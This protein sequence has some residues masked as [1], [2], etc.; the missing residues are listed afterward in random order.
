MC[1]SYGLNALRFHSWSPPE[2]AFA[3]ADE[4]GFYLQPE[5][6]SWSGFAP[7]SPTEQFIYE[8]ATRILAAFGN[9]PS[10]VMLAHGNEPWGEK[11]AKVLFS[12]VEHFKK[13]D[14]RRLY[15][16]KTG[17]S[18]LPGDPS[19]YMTLMHGADHTLMRGPG[20]WF[21][22]D[23][24]KGVA[25]IAAPIMTHEIGQ[26][27][28]LP[29][30]DSLIAS[31]TGYMRPGNLEVFRDI[32]R[33]TGMLPYN[34]AYFE[35]SG[36]FQVLC[37][38]E[39]IEANRRTP[40]IGGFQL[41]DLRDYLGQGTS[42]VGVV[43]PLWNPKSYVTPEAYRRFCGTTAPL[44]RM[45]RQVYR[46]GEK[47]K[48]EVEIAHDG[49][50]PLTGVKPYWK[51][52]RATGGVIARGTFAVTHI[53]TGTNTVLGTVEADLATWL[54]PA[55]YKLVVGL[56]GTDVENDWNFWL[57]PDEVTAP[58]RADIL[59]TH[60]FDAVEAR[61]SAGGKVLYLPRV[62]DLEWASPMTRDLPVFWNELLACRWDRFEGLWCD[63]KHPALASFPTDSHYD[64]Q[65][66]ELVERGR[67]R[68]M[69]LT[70]LNPDLKPIVHV[71]D[72]LARGQKLAMIFECRV[73]PGRLLVCSAD[74]D[75]QLET[76]SV[77]RQLRQSLLDYVASDKFQPSV[78]LVLAD[79][80][81]LLLDNLVMKKL[82]GQAKGDGQ[83]P[84]APASAAIDGDPSTFWQ[85]GP[86]GSGHH[87]H[88]LEVNF[89]EPVDIEGLIYLPRQNHY[90]ME[91]GIRG[92]RVEVSRDGMRWTAVAQ[93]EWPSSRDPQTVRFPTKKTVRGVRLTAISGVGDD[94]TAGVAELTVLYAGPTLPPFSGEAVQYKRVRTST[95]Q[96]VEP[97]GMESPAA[98]KAGPAKKGKGENEKE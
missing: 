38:K 6:G 12:W 45:T 81:T 66:R 76:R 35:S 52:L 67:C 23:Y 96:V 89:P 93:G 86:G 63:P 15:A 37:Y 47:L 85:A 92:Y 41:L 25:G 20:G 22:K 58:A 18:P 72:Q 3:A 73:G 11:S 71:I 62:G 91:G 61:L 53:P 69:R 48:I 97:D 24:R 95:A 10:F 21:G 1:K 80:R 56:D 36:R 75:N 42:L 30:F 88:W 74:V 17:I 13:L 28:A 59:V 60:D 46:S 7:G 51:V 68:A 34:Q 19:D 39:E 9:H 14:P 87:P 31:L 44:A 70:H 82:G 8:E 54:A 65:W 32:W 78:S 33:R 2:A 83:M 5:C 79:L 84:N 90:L 40:G 94:T 50:L 29:A 26:W 16:S 55:Q 27:V 98:G 57:Y 49:P 77:A 64:W 43:D 4:L